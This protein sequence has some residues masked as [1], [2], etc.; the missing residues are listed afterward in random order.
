M[1]DCYRGS[2]SVINVYVFRRCSGCLRE[3]QGYLKSGGKWGVTKC[4]ELE[5]QFDSMT[6]IFDLVFLILKKSII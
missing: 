6:M 4:L 1:A 3:F 5:I 2:I